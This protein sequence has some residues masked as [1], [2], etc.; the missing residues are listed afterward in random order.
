MTVNVLT[1]RNTPDRRGVNDRETILHPGNVDYTT[2]GRLGGYPVEG[3]VYAQP[4]YASRVDCGPRGLRD[5]VLVA[6]M[7]NAVYAFDA[8]LTGADAQVWRIGPLGRSVDSGL[9]EDYGDFYRKSIGV[10]STPVISLSGTGPVSGTIFLVAFEFDSA[11]F[12]ANGE[13][14][15]PAMFSHI[16]YALELGT[17]AILRKAAIAGRYPGGGYAKSPNLHAA[18]FSHGGRVR[19]DASTGIASMTIRFGS[20]DVEVVDASGLGGPSSAVHFNSCMQLQR[21]GLLL[22]DGSLLVAFGSRG[23]EDPYHGWLF[24]YDAATLTQTG[25]FCTTPN[26]IRGGI[27]QAGQGLVQ[28][29]KLNFYA[30]TGNGDNDGP[31]TGSLLLGR[32]LGESFVGFR[33]DGVGVRLNGWFSLFKDIGQSPS[34]ET[35]EDALDDDFGAG[36]PALLP[37]DRIVAGGKDGWLFLIDPDQLGKAGSSDAVP[38]AF[39]A[40]FNL[41]R[42]SR[43]GSAGR[44]QTSR[45]IHGSPVVWDAGTPGVFVYV[46]GENDVVR[47]YQYLPESHRDP[48][49]GRFLGQP[50]DF[51]IG[52][53]P[54]QGVDF[55]RGDVYASNEEAKRHGMPGGFLALSENAGAPGTAVLWAAYPPLQDANQGDVDGALVAYDASRFD[56]N[57]AYRRLTTLWS[58]RQVPGDQL[59]R[60]TKFC[61]PTVADGRVYQ[62]TGEGSVAIYGRRT[63]PLA[64]AL[65]FD[66]GGAGLALNGSALLSEGGTVIL[67]EHAKGK[68]ADIDDATPTFLAGSVFTRATV[69]VRRF[70]TNFTFVLTAAGADGFTFTVQAEGPRALGSSGS[71]LGYMVDRAAPYAPEMQATILHSFALKFGLRDRDGAPASRLALLVNGDQ[72]PGFI[73]VDLLSTVPGPIDLRSG[74]PIEARLRYDGS[75]LSVQLTDKTSG[76]STQE[77]GLVAG[78]I[79]QTINSVGGRAYVGFTGGTGDLSATQE[80][81]S[82]DFQ[83]PTA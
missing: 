5:L 18:R 19:I 43:I 24:S 35:V 28:D 61:C 69:D 54:A 4:L 55:A 65:G 22:Q 51:T 79:P 67:T 30:S 27:W 20:K 6:T 8:A 32:N 52:E 64:A 3:S 74:A 10:L 73:D 33:C 1:Q 26:G 59:G 44:G 9:F 62:A 38:Q 56:G 49:S 66:G 75:I 23:D 42:G 71:G 50:Q 46:W 15:T 39:K 17:G 14:A 76:V 80:I 13:V 21:P 25:I 77:F 12:A 11:A 81:V 78:D 68:E 29:S 47:A 40:S 48:R 53:V 58:S 16:L 57:L 70:E 31:G 60:F 34:P 7:E 83:A 63:A 36:A 37:D 82:W 45:H 72:M 41:A 2:F